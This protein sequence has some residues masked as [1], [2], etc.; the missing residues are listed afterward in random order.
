M[1][2]PRFVTSPDLAV[3]GKVPGEPSSADGAITS[4]VTVVETVSREPK[5]LDRCKW[6]VEISGLLNANQALSQLSYIPIISWCFW[7]GSNRRL[8][9]CERGTL[10]AEL[11]KHLVRLPSGKFRSRRCTCLRV[12]CDPRTLHNVFVIWLP[13]PDSNRRPVD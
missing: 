6:M 4:V 2:A 11:Q 7:T 1:P 8:P 5:G 13:K 12:L 9:R 10:T 3:T